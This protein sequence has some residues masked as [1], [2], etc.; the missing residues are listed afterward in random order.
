MQKIY[1]FSKTPAYILIAAIAILFLSCANEQNQKNQTRKAPEG[2]TILFDGNNADAWR[3]F[4]QEDLPAG[5]KVEDGLLIT[6][7]EGGDMGG[8]IISKKQFEDFM[9]ALEWK[10]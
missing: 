9:L 5:W 1:F 2:W 7:G 10:I 4:K 3:G 8:D 6:S